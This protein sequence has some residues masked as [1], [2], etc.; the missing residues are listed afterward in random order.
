MAPENLTKLERI[1]RAVFELPA[2]A[3]VAQVSQQL[4]PNWDSLR[5][6]TLVAAIENEFNVSLDIADSL[7]IISFATTRRLLEQRGA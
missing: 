3:E 6:V 4:Q 5:H 7:S 1:F 2:T